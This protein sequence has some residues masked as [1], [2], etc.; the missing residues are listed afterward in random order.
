[1][2]IREKH[3]GFLRNVELQFRLASA[4]R[5]A[6]TLERQP[7]D[8]PAEWSH[9]NHTVKYEE[10]ALHPLQADFAA[11]HLQR[12]ATY[13]M[14]VQIL[15]AIKETVP[16]A[17]THSNSSIR[18]AYQIS[19]MI[20]NSF[21][22]NPLQPVW[23][24][25]PDCLNQTFSIPGTIQFD[26]KLLQGKEFDWRDYGGPLALLRLNQ[27][28]RCEIL[29]DEPQAHSERV[30]RKPDVEVFQQG[31]LILTKLD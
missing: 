18:A 19:R 11:Y 2:D 27:Y 29:G 15:K 26:T 20:R 10:I 13:L 14:A 21:T 28:V 24:L 5:L 1:M 25:D 31:D 4:V 16:D 3:I 17:R 30:T 8:L 22:H 23:A 7:L 6:T 9:G 12:A